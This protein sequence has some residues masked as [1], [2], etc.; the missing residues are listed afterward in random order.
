[1]DLILYLSSTDV[2]IALKIA[3]IFYYMFTIYILIRHI[4]LNAKYKELK[5]NITKK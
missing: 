3:N 2:K 1:M 5:A 4:D